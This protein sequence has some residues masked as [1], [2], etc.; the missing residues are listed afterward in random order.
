MKHLGHRRQ[1]QAHEKN[2]AERGADGPE[3]ATV[4]IEKTD[5]GGPADRHG[6]RQVAD[7]ECDIAGAARDRVSGDGQETEVED[8]D[9]GAR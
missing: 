4:R 2:A 7:R 1:L 9:D 8:E 6:E 3:Q 5:S